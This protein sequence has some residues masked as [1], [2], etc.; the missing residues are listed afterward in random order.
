MILVGCQFQPGIASKPEAE[1]KEVVSFTKDAAKVKKCIYIGRVN[2]GEDGKPPRFPGLN[3]L[4]IKKIYDDSKPFEEPMGERE[5]LAVKKAISKDG[6]V[7]TIVASKLMRIGGRTFWLYRCNSAKPKFRKGKRPSAEDC[8][9]TPGSA[10]LP[11]DP[12][13]LP[14][15]ERGNPD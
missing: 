4:Q 13:C 2:L 9:F 1:E 7:D 8:E 10:G 11:Q 5:M 12:N 6:D 14:L 15:H 3:L